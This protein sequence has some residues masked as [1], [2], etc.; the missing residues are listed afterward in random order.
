MRIAIADDDVELAEKVEETAVNF[1]KSIGEPVTVGRFREGAVLLGEVAAGKI[2]DLY[3]LDVEM[4]GIDGLEVAGRIR[5]A[6]EDAN[7]AFFSGFEKYALPAY[8]VRACDYIV[9]GE[10]EEELLHL[11]ERIY[12]KLKAARNDYYFIQT[13]NWGKRIWFNDIIYLLK[14]KK[15]VQFFCTGG[16]C[17]R[18]RATLEEVYGRLPGEQFIYIN[19]GCII[20]MKHAISW[21]KDLI[22]LKGVDMKL[23]AS[24]GMAGKVREKLAEYWGT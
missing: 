4:P 10:N 3:I 8:K 6:D 13:E 23:A 11:L 14:E 1:G 19:R 22:G 7:I 12:G 21:R 15:Y 5:E 20:N 17:Y 18:E 24:R 16:L 2:Y 9:K